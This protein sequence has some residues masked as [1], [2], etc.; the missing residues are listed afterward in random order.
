MVSGDD[1]GSTQPHKF[2]NHLLKL[3]HPI[4]ING[5]EG[6][7]KNPE[8]RSAQHETSQGDTLLLPGRELATEGIGKGSQT[9]MP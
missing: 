7:V 1:H 3:H 5:G 6:F 8:G 2:A 4:A 9:H